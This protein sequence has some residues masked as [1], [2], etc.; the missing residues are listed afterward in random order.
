[1]FGHMH[2]HGMG[3]GMCPLVARGMVCPHCTRGSPEFLH[4]QRYGTCPLLARGI[5]CP[6]CKTTTASM[7]SGSSMMDMNQISKF[8]FRPMTVQEAKTY[9]LPEDNLV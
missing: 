2:G 3:M 8:R 9:F 5:V 1:M 6:H 7:A 4:M